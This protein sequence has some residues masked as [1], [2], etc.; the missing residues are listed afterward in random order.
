MED[1]LNCLENGRQPSIFVMEDDLITLKTEDGPLFYLKM[2]ENP[3]IK[4]EY[5]FNSFWKW[6]TILMLLQ[7]GI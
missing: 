3:N 1:H 7:G 5:D 6:K 2:E 4:M